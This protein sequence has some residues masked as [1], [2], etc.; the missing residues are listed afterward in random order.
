[1][2]EGFPIEV[3]HIGLPYRQETICEGFPMEMKHY[4]QDTDRKL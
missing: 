1:M 4:A 2:R 3:M